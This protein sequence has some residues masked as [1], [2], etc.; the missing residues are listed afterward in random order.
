MNFIITEFAGMIVIEP[1]VLTDARGIFMETFHR[2]KFVEVGLP[3]EFPQDNHSYSV[4]KVLRGLHYQIEHSQGKLVRAIRGEVYDV[5]VD[6]RRSSAMFGKWF[7]IVLSA[8]NK[9]QIYIPPGFAHGFCVLSD[10]AEVVYKCTDV[11]YPQHE[12]T[13]AWND[14]EIGIDWP[15]DDP[16][17]NA[18]DQAGVSLSDADLFA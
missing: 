4:A 10:D 1:R 5:A 18:K 13:I 17:V 9:K 14:P 12:R 8:E 15:I 6:L 16:V 3:A 2:D 7:G 11:Y